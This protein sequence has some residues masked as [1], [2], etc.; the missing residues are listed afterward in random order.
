M[1]SLP[2]DVKAY[3]K[4][5]VFNEETV[6]KA[7]LNDHN[8]KKGT[9]G[10]INILEGELVYTIQSEPQEVVQLSAEQFG[11]VEPEILHNVNPKGKVKFFVEFYKK[12][13]TAS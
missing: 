11:V 7:L 5:P 2:E 3:K 13:D 9:W 6:P 4:T 12:D 1:K 8:T 10:L